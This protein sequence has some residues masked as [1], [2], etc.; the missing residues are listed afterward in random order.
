MKPDR[1]LSRVS[2]GKR[3][4][5]GSF[6]DLSPLDI[7]FPAAE[8]GVTESKGRR[9]SRRSSAVRDCGNREVRGADF[10][11]LAMAT[12]WSCSISYLKGFGG[13]QK[14]RTLFPTIS[15]TFLSLLFFDLYNIFWEKK[16]SKDV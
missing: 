15:Y 8:T 1:I 16:G 6:S 4:A 5:M 14:I 13:K 11:G 2:W 7:L 12:I 9:Q 3:E 10:P